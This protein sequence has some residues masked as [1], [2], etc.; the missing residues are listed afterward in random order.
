[1][2]SPALIFA[3]RIAY[4]DGLSIQTFLP[5]ARDVGFFLNTSHFLD[6]SSRQI[7]G[8]SSILDPYSLFPYAPDEFDHLLSVVYL[9]GAVLGTDGSQKM[10]RGR[11]LERAL[12]KIL[13]TEQTNTTAGPD[14]HESRPDV[15]HLIQSHVLL[16][17]Y[18]FHDGEFSAGRK[19]TADAVSLV[20]TY[21][22]HKIR[23]PRPR[24]ASKLHL[25]HAADAEMTL[26]PPADL[27]E[28]GERIHAFWQVYIL[29]KTWATLLGCP[30]LLVDDG[31]PGTE[32]DTP[33]PLALEQYS[34][35]ST[36]KST[37]AY[38]IADQVPYAGHSPSRVWRVGPNDP[39]IHL[40][41]CHGR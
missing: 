17:N 35:V 3:I 39:N 31:S 1:M 9:W 16:A 33:W 12:Q 2:S 7:P 34:Q 8:S 6:W 11:Y 5:Y 10:N 19:H 15:V 30:S 41:A 14:S 36:R 25:V 28:E 26:H 20:V 13:K 40:E 22:L 4:F 29:D 27:L 38:R 18:F 23:S 21:Q 37:Q 32:I 24:D